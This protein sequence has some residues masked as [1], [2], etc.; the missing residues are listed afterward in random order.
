MLS[1]VYF[2]EVKMPELPEVE[3]IK[4]AIQKAIGTAN[5]INVSVNNNHFREIIPND[6]AER[7]KNAQI[8]SYRRV[9]KYIVIGLDN[10]L[11]LVWHLGMSGRVKICEKRPNEL[12]KHD[13]VIIETGNGTLIYNDARRFGMITYCATEK[14]KELPALAKAG[15]DPFDGKLTGE[16]LFRSFQNKK[17]SVKIALLDQEII[18]GIGNIYASEAL[19]TAGIL[20]ARA[21]GSLSKK[22]CGILVDAVRKILEQAIQAGGSTLRDYRKPDGSMGYFQNQH[23]VYNKTG[24]KCPGC[25]CNIEKTGGIQKIVQGGRSTFY[26]ATK[27]K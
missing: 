4:N 13:H 23:C 22:E 10:G 7:L 24:Q 26:C 27:Q 3:T 16:Y 6:F 14:L 17:T 25:S 20:P 1:N 15:I 11:S 9:A 2:F 8:I 21:A 19:F 18:S 5:I 12:A